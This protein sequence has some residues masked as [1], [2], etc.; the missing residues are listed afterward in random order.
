MFSRS[1]HEGPQP[2]RVRGIPRIDSSQIF[3]ERSQE[4]IFQIFNN[5]ADEERRIDQQRW[6]QACQQLNLNLSQIELER[7][8]CCMDPERKGK[9]GYGEFIAAIR[10]SPF[11]RSVVTAY[12]SKATSFTISSS[13]DYTK[14]TCANYAHPQPTDK[15]HFFGKYVAIRQHLESFQ[16]RYNFV[17]TKERQLLQDELVSRVALRSTRQVRPWLVYTCGPMGAG[18]TYALS[19][20]S[21]HGFFPLEY[22]VHMDP[23]HFK[24]AMPEWQGYLAQNQEAGT[25]C[26]AESKYIS[27]IGLEIALA[28][29]QNI[30]LD[31]SLRQPKYEARVIESIRQR[32]PLYHIAIFYVSCN[33]E[34]ALIRIEQRRQATGRGIPMEKFEDSFVAPTETLNLLTPKVDFVARIDSSGPEPRLDAFE[35]INRTGCFSIIQKQFAVETETPSSFPLALAPLTVQRATLDATAIVINP[36]HLLDN[37]VGSISGRLETSA[38]MGDPH[39]IAMLESSSVNSPRKA[40]LDHVTLF[41]SPKYPVNLD[42]KAKELA[43]IPP[44]AAAFVW[45]YTPATFRS[46]ALNPSLMSMLEIDA[47]NPNVAFFLY[48]GFIYFDINLK[49]IAINAVSGFHIDIDDKTRGMGLMRMDSNREVI[50]STGGAPLCSFLQ[51][52]SPNPLPKSVATVLEKQGRWHDVTLRRLQDRG[53]LRYAW[54]RP[55]EKFGKDTVSLYG[56]FAYQVLAKSPGSD[57]PTKRDIFFSVTAAV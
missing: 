11:L 50:H 5:L 48:G 55:L 20:L 12:T 37:H 41:M 2:S 44:N 45:C 42:T 19:W 36:K 18:K 27:E 16:S 43:L 31:G 1:K 17:F 3:I 33:R 49:V 15:I 7:I 32:Y 34:T 6:C 22:V 21:Q 23:D 26:H 46:L 14:D 54:I 52:E 35:V 57:K 8:F 53:A 4:D 51:F 47:A 30:W 25:L 24:S 40:K 9:I 56:A 10:Q 29:S 28:Q 38:M 39:L 13:Y